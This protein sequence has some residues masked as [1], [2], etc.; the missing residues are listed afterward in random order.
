MSL[1][2]TNVPEEEKSG[3]RTPATFSPRYS[4]EIIDEALTLGSIDYQ[5]RMT[6][7]SFFMKNKPLE[8][9]AQFL[10]EHYG[11]N[12][13]GFYVNDRPYT[14]WY[15]QDGIRLSAGESAQGQQ[16]QI[17]TWDQ[18][19]LR[20][21]E[22]LDAGH[23]LHRDELERAS[24]VEMGKLADDLLYFYR[25][26]SSEARDQGFLPTI[27]K[28]DKVKGGFDNEKQALL[29]LMRQPETYHMLEME[30]EAFGAAY[31]QNNQLLR[32]R[33]N[34]QPQL[35]RQI[36]DMQL[37]PIT[38]P[39]DPAF[40][41]QHRFFV[42]TDEMDHL[43]R[44]S[45]SDVYYRLGIYSFY[46]LHD[47]SKDRENYLKR[48]H[49]EYSGFG[50]INY[51]ILYSSKGMRYSR[52]SIA[53]PFAKA[54]WK[55]NKVEQRV[56][57]LI[58]QDRFLS[59][60]DRAAM[61]EYERHHIAGQIVSA[62]ANA[63]EEIQ[64]PFT[65]NP[66]LNYWE[67]VEQVQDQLSD[68]EKVESIRISLASLLS[69]TLPHDRNEE[70]RKKALETLEAYQKGAFSLFRKQEEPVQT[71]A[72]VIPSP[73]PA[74][75]APPIPEPVVEA[76]PAPK[77]PEQPPTPALHR[78]LT[79][80][81]IDQ[82]IL[83]WNGDPGSK[84][85]VARYMEQ[86][87]RER[88]TA[89]W[90][91]K[92]YG[93]DLPTFPVTVDGAAG[94]IPWARIQRDLARLIREERFI[95]EAERNQEAKQGE[96]TVVPPPAE[97]TLPENIETPTIAT[98]TTPGGIPYREGD[99]F[100]ILQMDG[101]YLLGTI[102]RVRDDRVWISSQAFPNERPFY[103][104]KAAFDENVDSG[105]Y[106]IV[107][108]ETGI[109]QTTPES[110]AEQRKRAEEI[111]MLPL[112]MEAAAEYNDL[113]AQHPDALIGF[114]QHGFYEFYGRDAE[115]AA[116]ILKSRI[117]TKEIPG[118]Q[119]KVTGFPT[120]RWQSGFR[121]LW[122]EGNDVY[123]AK[124]KADGTHEESKYLYGRDYIPVN[125]TVHIDN[126][127]YRVDTV[128]YT[129][130]R[131]RL[132][133][134]SPIPD[135]RFSPIRYE[136]IDTVR[137]RL[138]DEPDIPLS[139]ETQREMEAPFEEKS[140]EQPNQ[141][142]EEQPTQTEASEDSTTPQLMETVVELTAEGYQ[143]TTTR[144]VRQFQY[145]LM[146]H[147]IAF[148]DGEA[149]QVDRNGLFDVSF[150]PLE[151]NQVYPIARVESKERLETL[152]ARDERNNHLL[153]PATLE[154]RQ[155]AVT[156][157]QNAHT[158]QSEAP[159]TSQGA[160]VFVYGGYHF[161]PVGVFSQELSFSDITRETV[162]HTELGMTDG[163]DAVHP[164]THQAFFEAAHDVKADVFRCVETGKL[165]M[166]GEHELFEYIGAFE[167]F[168]PPERIIEPQEQPISPPVEITQQPRAENFRITDNHLGEGGAKTKFRNNLNAIY[169]L[170]LIESEGR[171]A[172]PEEQEVLSKYV[173]WG[174]LANAFDETKDDWAKEYAELKDA[175]TPD[176]YA[177]AR[178]STLN[179]HYTSPIV[180]RSI[181]DALQSMGFKEGNILEPAMG[182][183]NF[184]GV[185]P[186]A[187]R[188]SKLYGVELDSIT[189]RIAQQLY[190]QADIKV[191]GFETTDRRDFYD[192]AVGNVPFGNYKVND[193][194][195]N[196][197]GY[198]I[199]NYFFAKSLD[200]VRPGG[201]VAFVTSHYTMDAKSPEVRKYLA[202]R[203]DLLGAIRLPNNAF[204]ANAGTEVT[205]DIIFLQKR[206]S[207]SI[208][209]PSW[210]HLGET[211][212]G[213]PINS[214]FVDHP[215]MVL[216]QIALDKSMYGYEKSTACLPIEGADLSEQLSEAITHI[217][218][219]YK[220]AEL[221][222]L[223]EG[224]EIADSIPA[225]PS[226]KNYSYTVKDGEVYFRQNSVMVRP[227][228]NATAL[229]R[230]KGMVALR[231]CVNGLMDAQLADASDGAIA[232]R[233]A[234]LNRLY[235]NFTNRFGLINSRGNEL[236]FSDDSSYYLLCSLEVLDEEGNFERKA[237]MFTKRT[238]RQQKVIEHVDT[239][240]EALAVSI[241]ERAQVD[242]PYMA[243]LTGKS[244]DEITADLKG[245]IFQVPG[246]TDERGRPRYVTS[247]EYLS[248]NVRQKLR[249]ARAAA[250]TDPVFEVNVT[251][252]EEAQP[253]DL[254]AS[255]IEVRLGSTWVNKKYI[256]QFMYETFNTPNACRESPYSYAR[257]KHDIKVNFSEYTSEWGITNKNILSTTDVAAYTTFGTS[258]MNAYEILESTLNLRDVRIYDTIKDADGK[259]KRVLNSKETTLAQQKQQAIK[260]A[261]RDWIWQDPE[262]REELVRVYNERFN[263]T[264]TRE[265]DGSHIVFAGMNPEITL[266]EHQ[267]NAIAHILYGG[268][269]LLAHQVGA[270]KT[271]EMAAAAMESKRLGLC[272]KPMFVVP[273]HLTEQWASEFLRLYPSANILVTTK[274]DFEK[275]NRKKFCA[276]IATG[277]YDAV[278]IGHSQFEKIP[279]SYARQERLLEDQIDEITL[280]IEELK[281][282]RGERFSIKQLERTKKQLEARLEKLQNN[283]RKDDTVTF[284]Q[285]GVDR[286][287]VDEAHSFK[288]LF[289]YTKM[290]N[291]A[292]LSTSEAQKS[293]D[294]FLKCRY[295]DELTGNRGVIFATGTPISNSMTELYTMQ[296]YLQYDTLKQNGLIHFDAWASTFGETTTAIELAPEGTG[297]RARTRF[298]K[299]FNLPELMTMFREVAD[300]KTADQLNLP[301][302]EVHY[303]TIV[304]QPSVQQ[305][306][307]IA[308][309]SERASAIHNGMVDPS[310]D[311]MLKITSDGRKL[312]LDQRLINP[313]LP[314]DPNSKVNTCVKNIHRIWEEGQDQ[315]LTQLVFCDI[316]TPK[317]GVSSRTTKSVAKA[318]PDQINGEKVEEPES[319]DQLFENAGRFSVYEDIRE[320][321]IKSG[322]P[323]E[324]IAFIHDANTDVRKK[325][326][327]AKVRAGQVRVLL[328]ST[329]KMGA[330]TNVQDRLIA[331][332]DLDCPWRPGDLEQ[333]AGRIVRQ[334]NKN[335]EVYVFRYVT[336][337]TFDAYLWQT[338]ENKQR[339]ISQIQTSKSPVRSCEDVDAT[340]L[341]YAEIKACST[342]NP[343]IK[344][345]M[346]LD[347]DVAK[348]RIMRQDHESKKFK[349]EDRLR[350]Y[351][352]MTIKKNESL[353]EGLQADLK[354][355]EEHPLP[356]KGF[357]GMEIKGDVLTDKENAGAALI[358]A[359]KD[360]SGATS[361][362][363][364]YR[365]FT[366]FL[367]YDVMHNTYELSMQGQVSHRIELGEG[368]LGN[369]QRMENALK[370]IPQQIEETKAQLEN[371]EN[372][373]KAAKEEVSKPFPQEEELKTKSTRLAE[374]NAELNMEGKQRTQESE[375]DVSEPAAKRTPSHLD[376]S[377]KGQHLQQQKKRKVEAR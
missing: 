67:N 298:A 348:L 10:R 322:I 23:Y 244:E 362:I 301:T 264:R 297:Y 122:R 250:E 150:L 109:R 305:K 194:A 282:E 366:L 335:P 17:I 222:E 289:L 188:G 70:N 29:D 288:N 283:H 240:V 53:E 260:D 7:A 115:Q 356:E 131:V 37:T 103:V 38:F 124:E 234:E 281:E 66:I 181:Y 153:H 75:Q 130:H 30:L 214:Y 182:V 252:L 296:R 107:S 374:L 81:D 34:R 98:V 183:G 371:L 197:L 376:S 4:Q 145:D 95:T 149:Y 102:H 228:L 196:K 116:S 142:P 113:K 134:I 271:F 334:G 364:H 257:S 65:E 106:S 105:V 219:E 195:Y 49:G 158:Q 174:G 163:P 215:E 135:S 198:N 190:P 286:L 217:S 224:E 337:G 54:E 341:S 127:T 43:L 333:R 236:A 68:P 208:E 262:R 377:A 353:L 28:A 47:N 87:G 93:D 156:D 125:A 104:R 259:D 48:V 375:Q 363:G 57:T 323:S 352:P 274:K 344:E 351:F 110:R 241:G 139:M 178:A 84:Q 200:Q 212:D 346:E 243:W 202:E 324:Q 40:E 372:Q 350:K 123:L 320:K 295:L 151:G 86:H 165:Y 18:A 27:D 111:R 71:Q 328:G 16:A 184:F 101:S 140:H 253:Q 36:R 78:D 331:T 166:P 77:A 85:A 256:Q 141:V 365:G 336:K 138:E 31:A 361:M 73:Q 279:M 310:E 239:S 207:P 91:R 230:V 209:E 132:E 9:N 8:E 242:L 164:Y 369:L 270:G 221:S 290:N 300:I 225:D 97:A 26:L 231:D 302:P 72:P 112:S 303:D 327:F 338:Q 267:R 370:A 119:T 159:E 210:V 157:W 177:A 137:S 277:D 317:S 251:A 269:T 83:E 180:I 266:R 211:E 74:V 189:G 179:A 373:V 280:G 360:L 258:R 44:G 330:G 79:Q 114:E 342:D 76:E 285:L 321:L 94:D 220:E 92:E 312:G 186:E 226:V 146:Y 169:V 133:D 249:Q 349:L 294:M 309:L 307:M 246:A 237:D 229:E 45:T 155:Q 223:G 80:A 90:L 255:E 89:A 232:E 144:P 55:W 15:D 308:A 273:N 367:S 13:S 12:G 61:P 41:P 359:C 205:S 213:L 2:D 263:S 52:G 306:E 162:S 216:G 313:L 248:G 33:R 347:V 235:D 147:D 284:E 56:R 5:S 176:E 368:V 152:L 319:L 11:T 148:L 340:A 168:P 315:K 345:K 126:R 60:A 358:Q 35:L 100:Q 39:A 292:G 203:A 357:V 299:F 82:A 339:F 136:D 99:A 46:Q 118:G 14:I 206:E 218:G 25:D 6:I 154:Q 171:T 325:E 199:H 160:G 227:K 59:E 187:M 121:S 64:K 326:L 276:R 32:T 254:D 24:E 316:S 329:S 21:R 314:D 233:Q 51:D 88:G 1:F 343:L 278:I 192:L 204:K 69:M 193:R 42:S 19:A 201:I 272:Q 129:E 311:N 58:Q 247:D 293:S 117:V 172:T 50:N 318:A 268:N 175:L 191:A 143:A 161:E 167:P 173:G 245:I 354:T 275:A 3:E 20:I 108:Q 287:F 355:L 265:F 62:F 128:N 170:K 261:F 120:T 332:H 96:G 291:V 304:S 22:L 63:P 238:I 185:L